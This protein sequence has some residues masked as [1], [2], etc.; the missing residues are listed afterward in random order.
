MCVFVYV[1]NGFTALYMAAQENHVDVVRCLL[2]NAANQTL[3]TEALTL[4]YCCYASPSEGTIALWSN[5]KNKR[6][7]WIQNKYNHTKHE[8]T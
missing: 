3:A 6:H 2:L 5:K 7:C 1:Q 4:T 8:K